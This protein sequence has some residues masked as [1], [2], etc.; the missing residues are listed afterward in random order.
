M[1]TRPKKSDAG[2]APK[3]PR[4]AKSTTSLER[5]TI[6]PPSEVADMGLPGDSL[7]DFAPVSEAEVAERAYQLYEENGRQPGN[8]LDHWFRAESEIRGRFRR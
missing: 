5:S 7:V 6:P 1:A 8:D 4:S 2:D 3:R